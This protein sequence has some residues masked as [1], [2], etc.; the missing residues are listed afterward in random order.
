MDVDITVNVHDS[1]TNDAVE[2]AKVSIVRMK[3]DIE[4]TIIEGAQPDD[5][6]MTK[7]RINQNGEYLVK[8]EA[9]GY[10]ASK[11]NLDVSCDPS[12]CNQC[13][14]TILVP[15]SPTLEPD[16]LR[17]SLS[18]IGNP[19]DLDIYAF[20]RSSSDWE[21]SCL[22]YY[23]K[24]TSCQTATLDLDNR[25]GGNNGAE[26]ITFHN[27][28]DQQDQVYMIFVQNYGYNPSPREFKNSKAH[29]S[30]TDGIVN[31][32]ADMDISAYNG[33]KHWVAGC[34]KIVGNSFEFLPLNVYFNDQPDEDVPDM[35]L[36]S[37]GF[38]APTTKRPWYKF[39]G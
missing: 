23:S 5:D 24:K 18:W 33:E 32:N 7:A 9:D 25:H 29:I 19:E 12:S 36:D 10:I 8:V 37:F 4:Q 2:N 14:P 26:T 1:L 21:D 22:T 30:I 27:V 20:R 17:L 34:L 28:Q 35:C 38:Q 31:A 39:W 3:N 11:R 6:G 16:T 13:K 15:L